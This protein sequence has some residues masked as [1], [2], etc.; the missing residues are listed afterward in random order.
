MRKN[1][2]RCIIGLISVVFMSSLWGGEVAHGEVLPLL[3][4]VTEAKVLGDRFTAL[5]FNDIW[6]F[7]KRVFIGLE[8][9]V[10]ISAEP[11]ETIGTPAVNVTFDLGNQ[12]DKDGVLA[13][14]AICSDDA[15]A[16]TE[17]ILNATAAGN[18]VGQF[19]GV[20]TDATYTVINGA[21][22]ATSLDST[23]KTVGNITYDGLT[24]YLAANAICQASFGVNN[25]A[26]M[27]TEDEIVLTIHSDSS[28]FDLFTVKTF[29]WVSGGG[30]KY[31][32]GNPVD[33]CNGFNY[34]ALEDDAVIHVGNIWKLLQTVGGT[35]GA[36]PCVTPTQI[37]CC[38]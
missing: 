25:R 21:G 7:I 13:V 14:D 32:S 10:G 9:R 36:Q 30:S 29:G 23:G 6:E 33:D 24:G 37:A 1:T 17:D 8:D 12:L 16:T 15:C 5:D 19:V 20:T 38:I 26:H 28:A 22:T 3:D 4:H 34:G 35:G 18:G 27:C 31:T 11:R 2:K